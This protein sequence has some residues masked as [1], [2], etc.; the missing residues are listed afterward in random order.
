MLLSFAC[1]LSHPLSNSTGCVARR[2]TSALKEV[3][4]NLKVISKLRTGSVCLRRKV[5]TEGLA[6]SVT[7]LQ[8]LVGF[9]SC[10]QV[11]QIRLMNNE[12]RRFFC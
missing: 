12:K 4:V 10:D 5:G 8:T 2:G 3:L 9:C 7:Y 11:R 6:G 1:F